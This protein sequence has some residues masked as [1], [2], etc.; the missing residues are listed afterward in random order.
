MREYEL[1]LREIMR[2]VNCRSVV[3]IVWGCLQL[4]FIALNITETLR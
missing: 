2:G 3:E 4:L 1:A